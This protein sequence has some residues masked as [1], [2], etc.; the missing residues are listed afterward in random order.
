MA[1]KRTLSALVLALPLLANGLVTRRTICADGT[2]VANG[3]CCKLIPVVKD[4]TENL[5]EGECGDA[6][7]GALR[8]VFHDAIAISPTLGGGGADG[9]IAV[10]NATELT[11]HANTGIDD[12]L[13]AVGPFLLKHSDVMTPG[14]FIQ[15]AG[16]VSLTQCNGAPRVKFVMGR[17]P[18]KAAAPNLLVPEPFD[19]VATILQRFGELGFT[20]EETVAVIGGSHSVAGADD[21]VP[22]EQGIPFDQTPSIFDT[23]I[24]VDV[25]L[26]GTM[27]PGNGTTEGEVETAVPGTVRLQSDHL[28]ARDASTSCIWQSFV[29]QQSKMAQVFGEAIFK[30]SLLGQTQSK[31]IDCSEVIPRAI[32][33]SHGPATLPPGQTLKDIEQACAASPFP[34]LST[35]PGPVTSVP[36]IPQ[37]DDS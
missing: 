14:D 19:S 7:H 5:F 12:V 4:L 30:M 2:S 9:S 37:A 35:Q 13:D 22:N 17:P 25:Q 27:I 18:P 33:F 20:K 24:F 6:A 31:L 21:I 26:R 23:Q 29:N 3:A 15:L 16:A 34:T 11:F 36:A 8:L 1:F 10:F 32:P 28:L